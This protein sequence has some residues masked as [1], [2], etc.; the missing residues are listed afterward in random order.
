[1]LEALGKASGRSLPIIIDTPLGR[2]DS[3]H[4]EK[5]VESYF[6]RA[7]HQVIVLSTDTEVDQRFYDGLRPSVSHAFHL[8]FDQAERSTA[9]EEGYFW[10]TKELANAA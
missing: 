1:M 5:L 6:P 7:S 4:R 10:K 9:A 3:K 2:L 8:K